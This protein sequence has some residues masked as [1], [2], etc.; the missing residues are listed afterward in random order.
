[1]EGLLSQPELTATLKCPFLN[2]HDHRHR[3][4]LLVLKQP[5]VLPI[6]EA[7]PVLMH[8]AEILHVVPLG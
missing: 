6:L 5:F 1:M 3:F 8:T 4:S 7:K 2:I